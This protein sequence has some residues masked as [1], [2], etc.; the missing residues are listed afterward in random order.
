[1]SKFEKAPRIPE[2]CNLKKLKRD[3]WTNLLDESPQTPLRSRV[4]AIMRPKGLSGDMWNRRAEYNRP[5]ARYQRERGKHLPISVLGRIE[6][7]AAA[8]APRERLASFE[9]CCIVDVAVEK[10]AIVRTTAPINR[11]TNKAQRKTNSPS[12]ALHHGLPQQQYHD[13]NLT[14]ES[15]TRILKCTTVA[16]NRRPVLQ[17][18]F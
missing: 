15:P 10:I 7:I 8:L 9:A 14:K 16:V 5:T 1:M 11:C 2:G 6:S 17:Q 4:P 3:Y 12:C 18:L 13:Q